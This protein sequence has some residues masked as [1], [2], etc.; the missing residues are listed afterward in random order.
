MRG[1]L[2]FCLA[3][4]AA[5][6]Q[7]AWAEPL[8]IRIAPQPLGKALSELGRQSGLQIIYRPQIIG[9][10]MTSGLNGAYEPVAALRQL[11][12][13]TGLTYV[14]SGSG[15]IIQEQAVRTPVSALQSAPSAP[16]APVEPAEAERATPEEIIVTGSRTIKNGDDSPTPVT[17]VTTETLQ[18]VRPTSLTE[19]IQVMPVFSGSRGQT[20]N[21]SATGA[22][23]GGNGSAA[24][25]NLRNI[26]SQRNLV[27]M[28]GRRV[29]PTSFTGIVD[30]DVIPQLL[31]QR[32]DVVTGGVSAV[33]GSDAVTGVINFVTD[34]A[35]TGLKAQAQGGISS[36]HDDG[37]QEL[38]LA[39]GTKIGERSHFE[40]SYEY[41]NSDGIA[42]RSEREWFNRA[43]VIGN[44]TTVPYLSIGDSAL[45]NQP[46]GGRITACGT[47]CTLAGQY[48]AADGVLSPFVA[49]TTYSG[50]TATQSGGAG[51]YFDTSLK[52]SQRSHQVFARFDTE[53]SDTVNFFASA[54]ANFKKNVFY[55]DELSLS[56][57]TM[58]KTNAF[59]SPVYQA[60]I[61]AA[62]FTFG[63]VFKQE[64]R[65]TMVPNTRQLSFVT[66]F[67][68][69]FGS[70][71]WDVGYVHGE[72][73]L[74]TDLYNNPN[75]QK[76][77]AALDAVPGSG[78]Q[79]VCYAA[80]QAATAA[81]YADC[82][83]LNVFGPSASSA[84]ARDY[85][86]DDTHYVATTK[87]DDIT[88]S[89]SGSPFATWAGPVNVA[90]SGEWRT[91][92]FQSQSNSAADGVADC[93][94]LRFNCVATGSR[95]LLLQNVFSSSPKVS[96]NVWEAA[97]E[98]SVPL[99]KDAPLLQLVEVTGAARYTKYN[100]VGSYTT[101]KLGGSWVVSD[102]LRFRGT[103]S[104]DIRAPTLGDLY[105]PTVQS[106][107]TVADQK[108]IVSLPVTQR[109][110]A[111][112]G[113]TAEIGNTKTVGLVFKPRFLPGFSLA[114][115]Y[116]DIAINNA[117][118]SVQGSQ[119]IIQN[120]CNLSG[121]A[122]YCD[123][124]ERDSTGKLIAVVT[125]PINLAK[126]TTHGVDAE[127]NYQGRLFGNRFMFRGLA[128][129]QPHIRYIQP[130]VPT[131]DQGG[132]AF[133]T[134]GLTASPSLRLTG[135]L[136]YDVTDNLRVDIMERWRSALKLSGDPTLAFVAGDNRIRPYAQTS[137]NVAYS[138]DRQFQ[139]SLN[140]QNLFDADPPVGNAPGTGGA[141][142]HFGGFS[143]TDD[144]AGRYFTV[145]V[146]LRY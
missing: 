14:A 5:V 30:A 36:R 84:A 52:A 125:K 135:I 95:T 53:L 10:R 103:I 59:L 4:V 140:V 100:S 81:A 49:G 64:S 76:L 91:Q 78:G 67:D 113:L 54:S 133:G 112:P 115:D 79:P 83:P 40:I 92:S 102:D 107:A 136:S 97:V 77:A 48:F 46:F 75:Q 27:L 2:A 63:Q 123:L 142:G 16:R 85:I 65:L 13:G 130:G 94:N 108:N 106:V 43:T 127:L 18:N 28:D 129:Y 126:I 101:W 32:V 145:G 39:W 72:S 90:L 69:K 38:G 93:T 120:G 3:S 8:A 80:T 60:L 134:A 66:G 11:L 37:S 33:Y 122:L 111:N 137:L 51:G 116:F 105:A 62:T 73:R 25:L 47:G 61:P 21:P 23:G 82:V 70:Y 118:V 110:Q 29:P 114:L 117:I 44:G 22:T 86:F 68:G 19:S 7:A 139:L 31:I 42:R 50:V 20:A 35:F 124:I 143:A 138:I 56:G 71:S 141:P 15:F 12:A 24:Q 6:P 109:N 121:I 131:V 17:V 144:V 41:R 87:Q 45:P 88:A 57:I 74:T 55:G 9:R 99:V 104:R 146:R 98:A 132:V 26:G 128:A 1:Y 58:S 89:I 96:M 34:T 119:A